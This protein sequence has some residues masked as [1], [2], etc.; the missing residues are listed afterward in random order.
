MNDYFNQFKQIDLKEALKF[1]YNVSATFPKRKI[2]FLLSNFT[3]AKSAKLEFSELINTIPEW[4]RH[5]ITRDSDAQ[6][7]TGFENGLVVYFMHS[8]DNLKG[9]TIDGLFASSGYSEGA[10]AKI[11][12]CFAHCS[13][14]QIIK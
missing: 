2:V 1:T 11:I 8:P 9:F 4:A 10:L 3:Q 7:R 12:P 13:F 5:K 14:I 6:L